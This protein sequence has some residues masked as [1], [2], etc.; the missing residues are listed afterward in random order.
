MGQKIGCGGHLK[1]LRRTASG[2]LR[3]EQA[4]TLEQLLQ[5]PLP[6]LEQRL[7]PVHA[8]APRVVL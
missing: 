2:D 4:L 1:A 3:V 8:A 7:I 6:D 5:M